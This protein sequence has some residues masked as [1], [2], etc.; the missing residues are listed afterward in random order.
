MNNKEAIR[1][2][3]ETVRPLAEKIRAMKAELNAARI[4]WYS[5]M[6]AHFNKGIEP[7]EDERETE[8]VSRLTCDDVT[9]FMSQA[10]KTA[11]AEASA[12]N[13][14]VVSKPCVRTFQAS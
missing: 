8:G 7:V 9:N 11:E 10:I 5:G 14:Q 3:N 12:W 1:F 6:N 4:V 2:V 13:D